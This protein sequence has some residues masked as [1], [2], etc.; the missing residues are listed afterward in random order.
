MESDQAFSFD[1]SKSHH[2]IF[3]HPGSMFRAWIWWLLDK[4]NCLWWSLWFSSTKLSNCHDGVDWSI[5]WGLMSIFR[6]LIWARNQLK[7]DDDHWLCL[8]LVSGFVAMIF[9][10]PICFVSKCLDVG[11]LIHPWQV[12][13]FL[14]WILSF[15]DIVLHGQPCCQETRTSSLIFLEGKWVFRCVVLWEPSKVWQ[16]FAWTMFWSQPSRERQ[17]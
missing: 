17:K 11:C 2:K 14:L 1:L 12:R 9:I 8:T 13:R 7:V 5:R 3:C 16:D 15:V 6:S 4:V 10:T